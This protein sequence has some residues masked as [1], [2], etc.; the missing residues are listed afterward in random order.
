MSC[1]SY[2]YAYF[3]GILFWRD[4][5][6]G[7]ILWKAIS[8]L[9]CL[10]PLCSAH[11]AAKDAAYCITVSSLEDHGTN[12]SLS[13]VL[14]IA[15]L[16]LSTV[17]LVEK[18][19]VQSYFSVFIGCYVAWSHMLSVLLASLKSCGLCC[20]HSPSS[21]SLTFPLLCFPPILIYFICQ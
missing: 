9:F 5:Y 6:F 16:L 1:I 15:G 14:G 3:G 17:C 13:L 8:V 20:A 21:F 10:S 12:F 4:A 2:A 7:G 19:T 18:S 11:V